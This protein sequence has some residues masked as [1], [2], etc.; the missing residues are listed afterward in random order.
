MTL[1]Q[2]TTSP[3]VRALLKEQRCRAVVAA[4][5]RELAVFGKDEEVLAALVPL[6]AQIAGTVDLDATR[7]SWAL[8]LLYDALVKALSR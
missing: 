3:T 4:N 7:D 8:G 2:A 6:G 5:G 1:A